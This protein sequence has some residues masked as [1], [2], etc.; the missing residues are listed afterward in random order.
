MANPAIQPKDID[1]ARAGVITDAMLESCA[2]NADAL[3][4]GTISN[5]AGLMLMMCMGPLLRELIAHRAKASG[6]TDLPEPDGIDT[7][8]VVS[9]TRGE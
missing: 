9:I 1:K 7:S 2:H 8:N 4:D 5:E 3:A 6:N